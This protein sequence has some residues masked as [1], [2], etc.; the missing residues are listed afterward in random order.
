MF[1]FQWNWFSGQ[2]VL[3]KIVFYLSRSLVIYGLLFIASLTD[4]LCSTFCV[5]E[6][7]VGQSDIEM[8]ETFPP[9]IQWPTWEY[10]Q[11]LLTHLRHCCI[12]KFMCGD[13]VLKQ[14]WDTSFLSICEYCTDMCETSLQIVICDCASALWMC[15]LFLVDRCQS[16]NLCSDFEL[17]MKHLSPVCPPHKNQ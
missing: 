7:L 6:R 5:W 2:N 9:L 14:D 17:K 3:F 16:D 11:T 1:F 4:F 13:A 15:D 10:I 8:K 12:I